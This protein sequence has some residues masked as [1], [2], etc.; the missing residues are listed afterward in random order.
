[1]K[2]RYV[3]LSVAV[4]A[5]ALF[6]LKA[7]WWAWTLLIAVWLVVVISGSSLLRWQ[8]HLP[9]LF[10]SPQKR[11]DRVAITFDDG[12]DPV[13]T[14]QVLKLLAD[15]GAKAT[16]FCIGKRVQA[17]P[18]IVKDIIGQGHTLGNHS[19]SHSKAF[20]FKSTGAVIIE[21]QETE[22]TVQEQTGLSMRLFRPPFGVTNPQIARAVAAQ[23]LVCVGWSIRSLDTTWRSADQVW[24]R[25]V[26]QLKGG[27]VVL[28]HDSGEKC[29]VVLERL[30]TFLRANKL[31]AVP[32][33]SLLGIK[34][35]RG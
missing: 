10:R 30:L 24:K 3:I 4:L 9:V 21:L 20:G 22:R 34:P 28:L 32:V 5:I 11:D 12:P 23:D 7:P 1:M 27:E 33:D 19:F 13:I 8:Y 35:Y 6:L 14:P 16:F 15:H 29:V 31:S 18:G 26:R 25:I 2:H 17:Y